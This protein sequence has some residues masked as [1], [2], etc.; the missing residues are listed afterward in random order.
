MYVVTPHRNRIGKTVPMRRHNVC[1]NEKFVVWPKKISFD[2]SLSLNC[3]D[4][5]KQGGG[6]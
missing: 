5:Y 6:A 2:V 1:V 3:T 4:L